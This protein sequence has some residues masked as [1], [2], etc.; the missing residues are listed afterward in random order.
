[1]QTYKRGRCTRLQEGISCSFTN[2]GDTLFIFDFPVA[3]FLL[4]YPPAAFHFYA[5][6]YTASGKSMVSKIAYCLEFK[7]IQ[8]F[9]IL[10]KTK[11]Q[12]FAYQVQANV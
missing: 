7:Y 4:F 6:L 3:D 1:M 2:I 12:L 11:I 9:S 8:L 5:A 10:F